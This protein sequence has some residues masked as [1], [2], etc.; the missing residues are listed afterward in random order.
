MKTFYGLL[1]ALILPFV[2]GAA[3]NKL[4]DYRLNVAPF[5]QLTVVDGVSVDYYCNPD[6]AGWAVFSASPETAS[7]ITFQN[8]KEHLTIQTTADEHPLTGMPKV[9]VYSASLMNVENSGDSLVRVFLTE[10]VKEFKARQIGNGTLEIHGVDVQQFDGVVAAGKG[11]MNVEGKSDKAKF[12]NVSTGPIMAD[13]LSSREVSC[14]LFGSGKVYCTPLSYLK[15]LGAG[16]GKVYYSRLPEKIVNRSI[17]VK[18]GM[19]SEEE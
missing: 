14:F 6:S 17:G 13:G 3:E 11:G 16:T 1:I 4:A 7:Q 19:I 12:R 10:P 5:R 8:N 18:A 15:I 2:C 9:K